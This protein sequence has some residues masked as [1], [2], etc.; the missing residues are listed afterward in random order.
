MPSNNP[1]ENDPW[2]QQSAAGQVKDYLVS[3]YTP[4]FWAGM[5]TANPRMWSIGEG[6]YVPFIGRYLE[7]PREGLSALRHIGRSYR[8]R[9]IIGGTVTAIGRTIRAA[10]RGGMVGQRF[11]R[12][13]E[14]AST[15]LKEIQANI[16]SRFRTESVLRTK[17]GHRVGLV[18]REFD[19]FV[20]A[21]G[22]RVVSAMRTGKKTAAITLPGMKGTLGSVSVKQATRGLSKT[23]SS[24]LMKGGLGKAAL[25]TPLKLGLAAGKAL[26][27]VG[28]AMFAWDLIKAVGEPLG[29]AAMSTAYSTAQRIQDRFMP[30][31]GGSLSVA[32]LTRQAATERQRA[33]QAMSKASI[34]GR[35]AF[36]QE[37]AMMHM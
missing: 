5:Y 37:A 29:A 11:F 6:V 3:P 30:E 22:R 35:S 12:T 27:T 26:S 18:G 33:L 20:E 2:G 16:A 25:R 21:T 1:Y 24:A 31:M 34:T 36:G 4:G 14:L 13:G 9:G 7:N 28:L 32:Y 19:E 15:G 8:G 17:I 10:H 23:S